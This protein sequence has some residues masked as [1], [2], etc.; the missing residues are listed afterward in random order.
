MRDDV[1]DGRS[2]VPDFV[3]ERYAGV[4]GRAAQRYNV[5][6]TLL[7]AQLYAESGFNPFAVSSA[8]AQGAQGAGTPAAGAT[9]PAAAGPGSPTPYEADIQAAAQRHGLDPSLLKALIKQES[10]FNAKAGSPAGAQGLTQLMPGTAQML[11][12]RD[13]ADPAQNLD[14]GARYLV[15]LLRAFRSKPLALAAYNAGPGAVQR[16]GCVPPYPETK[17]Y[18]AKII[19]LLGGAG[20]LTAGAPGGLEVRLVE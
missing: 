14:G 13:P 8:G 17:A 2:A 18:V 1:G 7:S 3:P 15:A 11:A 19:G 9:M 10:N 20:D 4:I 16:C 5:S 6:S 12:V